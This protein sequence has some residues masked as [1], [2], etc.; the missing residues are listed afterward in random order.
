MSPHAVT[1]LVNTEPPRCIRRSCL[2]Q[3]SFSGFVGFMKAAATGT[4]ERR[5]FALFAED[6]DDRQVD[7][8]LSLML[9]AGLVEEDGSTKTRGRPEICVSGAFVESWKKAGDSA[10]AQFELFREA[11]EL[12]WGGTAT[13]ETVLEKFDAARAEC[14]STGASEM[15]VREEA[16]QRATAAV[17]AMKW[18]GP[19]IRD[20]T[21]Y[22]ALKEAYDYLYSEYQKV[23]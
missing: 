8:F 3:L 9:A 2:P 16:I 21:L 20:G 14:A 11:R 22:R 10:R 6:R 17:N 7:Y 23:D 13:K 19:V 12:A 5:Q 1:T 18:E 4:T 15:A